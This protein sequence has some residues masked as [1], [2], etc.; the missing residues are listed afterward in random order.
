MTS[1]VAFIDESGDEGFTF[2][3]DGSGSTRWFVLSAAV[4]RKENEGQAVHALQAARA[5][6]GWS[7]KQDFHFSN[8][9]HEQR[10][11]L[12]HSI[13]NLPFRTVSILS[14]KPDI[15]DKE[16]YQ[17]NKHLLYRYLTRLL[18]E[19]ISWLCR[20]AKLG[21]GDGTVEL[22]FSDRASMSYADLR[23]YI[24]LLHKQSQLGQPIQI[25]WPAVSSDKI[26]AVAH[27]QR[28]GLQIADAVATSTFYAVKL[29]RFGIAD[30]SYLQFIRGQVYRRKTVFIGYGVK[31][32]SNFDGLKVKMPHLN[33]AFKDW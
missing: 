31:F 14:Y 25:H 32:L 21:E 28:A 6:L 19:R 12:M 33:A 5:K 2:R 18:L 15:T 17:A 16:N 27:S 20:D 7:K 8:L 22:I 23:G 3:E 9:K 10:L 1:F 24:D 26:R 11:V 4:F 29:S 30:P 13:Q